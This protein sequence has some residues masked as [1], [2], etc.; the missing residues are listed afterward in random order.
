M[1]KK[2][3]VS[4]ELM[5]VIGFILVF[6][7]PLLMIAY[8]QM[9]DLNQDLSE[10]QANVAVSRLANTINSIGRM[11]VGSSIILDVY[12]PPGSELELEEY[13]KGG[14]IILS[15]DKLSGPSE[16]VGVTWF[17]IN[18]LSSLPGGLNY[19]FNITAQEDMVFVEVHS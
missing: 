12:L 15:L 8:F 18:S 10:I 13:D 9:I 6:F 19:R 1:F 2:G 14:E 16:I 4:V 17:K 11:G 3:Q 5:I 7:I